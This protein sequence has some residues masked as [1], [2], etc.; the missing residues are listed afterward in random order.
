MGDPLQALSQRGRT[1]GLD[2]IEQLHHF[3]FR[4][5]SRA[6]SENRYLSRIIEAHYEPLYL[7]TFSPFTMVIE[8]MDV[9][10]VLVVFRGNDR[11]HR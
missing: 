2:F 11:E 7:E 8:E 6:A 1:A 3:T 4:L 5:T 9:N 10:P